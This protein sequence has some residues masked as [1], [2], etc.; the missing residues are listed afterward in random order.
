MSVL[1]QKFGGTSVADIDRMRHVASIVADE[2]RAGRDVVVV[3]NFNFNFNS[4][5][6]LKET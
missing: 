4:N 5:F 3:V 6:N 2:R 1:V